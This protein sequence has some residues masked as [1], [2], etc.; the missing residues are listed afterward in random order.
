MLGPRRPAFERRETRFP[1][2]PVAPAPT[3]ARRGD[4]S[5]CEPVETEIWTGT[6]VCPSIPSGSP[7]ARS[8]SRSAPSSRF[9]RAIP[10]CAPVDASPSAVKRMSNVTAPLLVVR[11]GAG[12]PPTRAIP[13]ALR[14]PPARSSGEVLEDDVAAGRVV[15]RDRDRLAGHVPDVLHPAVGGDGVLAHGHRGLIPRGFHRAGESRAPRRQQQPAQERQPGREGAQGDPRFRLLRSR[16]LRDA[17]E[18]L[19]PGAAYGLRGRG[20]ACDVTSIVLAR[21]QA[22]GS[23]CCP[24]GR[25]SVPAGARCG[26]GC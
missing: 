16:D 12:V 21:P 9:G 5:S 15:E 3:R 18:R 1:R 19:A 6:V 13:A 23:A 14:R 26:V 11:P 22:P 17:G 25:T 7:V 10:T 8:Q 4:Q 24:S 2:R 20:G